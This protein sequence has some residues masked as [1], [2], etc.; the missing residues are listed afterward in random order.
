MQVDTRTSFID[1]LLSGQMNLFV[2]FIMALLLISPTKKEDGN[3]KSKAE[4][5]LTIDWNAGDCDVDLWVRGPDAVVW[6]KNRDAGNAH[7]ER[8]DTGDHND[9]LSGINEESWVM[10]GIA[11]GEY[12][13]NV[14]MYRM[15]SSCKGNVVKAELR[16]LNPITTILKSASVKL[17]LPSQE[18]HLF[19]FSVDAVGNVTRI[20]DEPAIIAGKYVTPTTS[21]P[22]QVPFP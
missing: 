1:M 2:V 4:M 9:K 8:D 16:K 5:I 19:R 11:P 17:D 3:V 21:S 22:T 7:L 13:A 20:W 10:R 14:H 6:W 15:D 18:D 12:V